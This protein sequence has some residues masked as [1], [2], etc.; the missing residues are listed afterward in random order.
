MQSPR[1]TLLAAL[2]L[3]AAIACV[4]LLTACKGPPGPPGPQGPPGPPGPTGPTGPAGPTGFAGPPGPPGPA[5][6]VGPT[7][8]TGP[9]GPTGAAAPTVAPAPAPGSTGAAPANPPA[10][11]A[12]LVKEDIKVGEG[13]EVKPGDTVTV[14]YRG[15]LADGSEFDS[16][17]KP[18]DAG[19]VEPATFSLARVIPGWQQGIP[20]MKVGGK[21]RLVVPPALAYG[22]KD[23]TGP[24]GKVVIPA[25]STLTFEVELLDVKHKQ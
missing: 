4:A 10:P 19:K 22:D 9:R 25:N 16:S 2:A 1:C 21:R 24:G 5:G 18:N 13:E 15:T 23:I 11:A 14:H 17:Y 20:G 12:P 6:P 3:F 8:P 7:G